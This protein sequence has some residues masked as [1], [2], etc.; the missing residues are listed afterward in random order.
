MRRQGLP[1]RS[2]RGERQPFIGAS[3]KIPKG[4]AM[5]NRPFLLN[6]LVLGLLVVGLAACG[7]TWQGLKQDTG[8]NVEATG[9]VIERAGEAVRQ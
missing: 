7:D 6:F 1:L 4:T 9:R 5:L 2:P 3:H 8:E